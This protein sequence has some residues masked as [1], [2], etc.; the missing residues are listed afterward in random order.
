MASQHMYVYE[1]WPFWTLYYHQS[2][3][4]ATH[5]YVAVAGLAG[6]ESREG[7]GAS[8]KCWNVARASSKAAESWLTS[9]RDI[10]RV[11]LLRSFFFWA[12]TIL[13]AITA[14]RDCFS[15]AWWTL[16]LASLEQPCPQVWKFSLSRRPHLFVGVFPIRAHQLRFQLTRT[17]TGVIRWKAW[18][19]CYGCNKM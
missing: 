17:N 18:I 16:L 13:A 12:A 3:S 8:V 5:L 2:E 11:L 1:R 9:G 7:N 4:G 14:T 6:L 19:G 10:E 15:S